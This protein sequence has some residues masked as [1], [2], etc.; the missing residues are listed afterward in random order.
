MAGYRPDRERLKEACDRAVVDRAFQPRSGLTFCNFAVDSI[1]MAMGSGVARDKH[2]IMMAN[3]IVNRLETGHY[4]VKCDEKEACEWA[5]RGA[6]IIAGAK[7]KPN[8]HVAVVYPSGKM[9]HSAKWGKDVPECANV[10]KKSGIM[11]VNWAFS[12]EPAYFLV[13]PF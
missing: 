8:G 7:A 12:D 3:D 1:C 10:G 5:A 2:G 11:G 9:S 13:I 4:A 6:I